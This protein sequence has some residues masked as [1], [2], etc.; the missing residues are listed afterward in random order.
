MAEPERNSDGTL[1][2]YSD[3]AMRVRFKTFTGY[4]ETITIPFQSKLSHLRQYL[5]D[6]YSFSHEM[7][8]TLGGIVLTN[9]DKLLVQDY[10]L[11][12]TGSEIFILNVTGR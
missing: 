9:E 12:E 8:I 5:Q 2:E 6:R 11:M 1:T 7:K 3:R 10:G 4:D